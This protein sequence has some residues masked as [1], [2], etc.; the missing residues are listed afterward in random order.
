M[1]NLITYNSETGEIIPNN[2]SCKKFNKMPDFVMCFTEGLGLFKNLSKA[3]ILVTFELLKVVNRDNEIMPVPGLK[4]RIAKN[5]DLSLNSIDVIL[6]RLKK[7]NILS[8][9]RDEH[10]KIKE[11]GI[12]ILNPNIFGKNS[13][14]T[15]KKLRMS[16]EWDF[17]KLTQKVEFEQENYSPRELLEV[18]LKRHEAEARRIKSELAAGSVV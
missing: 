5:M 14:A 18:E 17:E 1:E 13:W 12:Y 6:F 11:R 10:G 9:P 2:K 7:K 3:E 15:I 8:Q 4:E 16:M